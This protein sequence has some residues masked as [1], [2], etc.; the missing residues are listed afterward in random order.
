MKDKIVLDLE[1][2]KTFAE[3]GKN[4]LHLM[5][6]SVAG[7]YSY[8]RDDF[9]FFGEDDI[10]SLLSLL[11]ESSLVIGFNIKNF[12]YL[13]LRPYFPKDISHLPS[14]D[15]LEEVE[16]ALGHRLKLQ[17]LVTA[18]LGETKLGDGLDAI[19]YFRNGEMDKL[20]EYCKHDVYLTR[21][22]YEYGRKH[23][24]IHYQSRFGKGTIPVSWP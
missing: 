21:C 23:G 12:D 4:N 16:L 9:L 15:I 24:Q 22:L 8:C 17:Y 20:K 19:R 18:T 7:I 6:I 1:T 14:L 2:Q 10:L 3:V 5:R 13:V 11:E